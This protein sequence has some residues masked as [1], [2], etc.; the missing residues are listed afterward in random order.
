MF[1]S[2]MVT[3]SS[4]ALSIL[5]IKPPPA[6]RLYNENIADILHYIIASCIILII[7]TV[8]QETVRVYPL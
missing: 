5:L 8:L 6:T 1:Q 4:Y 2:I 7:I 3:I